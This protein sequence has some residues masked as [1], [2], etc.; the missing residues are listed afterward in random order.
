MALNKKQLE[1]AIDDMVNHGQ[2]RFAT[3]GERRVYAYAYVRSM[4]VD[5][6]MQDSLVYRSL[7]RKHNKTFEK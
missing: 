1:K 5:L 7:V 6:A 3:E 2:R 4:L